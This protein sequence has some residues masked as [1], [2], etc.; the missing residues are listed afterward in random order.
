M[1][2]PKIIPPSTISLLTTFQCTAS[3][4][5]CCFGCN[6]NIKVRMTLKQMRAYIDKSL[7]AYKESIK[8]QH[9]INHFN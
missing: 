6:P 3:C 1:D 2:T 5:N 7:A 8:V 9:F 4:K